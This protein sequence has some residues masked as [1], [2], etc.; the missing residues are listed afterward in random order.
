M[1]EENEEEK[2]KE[3]TKS[4]CS[5]SVNKSQNN[6]KLKDPAEFDNLPQIFSNCDNNGI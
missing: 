2:P 4:K 6:F 5:Y 1:D 3:T